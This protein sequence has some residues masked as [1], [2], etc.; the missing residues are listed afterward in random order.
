MFCRIVASVTFLREAS[1]GGYF[2]GGEGG[3]SLFCCD[4]TL[5]GG[6]GQETGTDKANLTHWLWAHYRDILMLLHPQSL[7]IKAEWLPFLKHN[8]V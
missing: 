3:G 4:I 5:S 2:S 8:G 6:G 1:K 7:G